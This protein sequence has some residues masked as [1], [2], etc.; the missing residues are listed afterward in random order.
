MSDILNE[1]YVKEGFPAAKKLYEIA[2]ERNLKVTMKQV[3]DFLANQET[4][5]L[6]RRKP[7]HI[8]RPI[9]TGAPQSEYQMD[10][11][12][13]SKFWHDN[14]GNRW[15][16]ICVDIFSRRASAQ[17][18]KDK[19]AETCL[20]ALKEVLKELGK[21]D[22]IVHDSGSEYKGAVAKYLKE[23]GI[24]Q[25]VTQPLDHHI[26]GIIDRF[27]Q[28]IKVIIYKYFTHNDTTKWIDEL[29]KIIKNYNMQVHSS[30]GGM[31]PND[32]NKYAS[33]VRKVQSERMEKREPVKK[34]NV[35]DTVKIKIHKGTFAKG[36]TINW[37]TDNYTIKETDGINYELSNGKS[38]RADSLFKVVPV[39]RTEPKKDVV[40]IAHKKHRTEQILKSD[41]IEEKNVQRTLRSR[42]PTDQLE[43]VRFGKI[44][45]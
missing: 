14:G 35:G 43:D 30:L 18:M 41:S 3:Q 23:E 19:K 25:R 12:D 29:P 5:Q 21:P 37:S 45:Y 40:K 7:K 17:A 16:L 10:L 15:I 39:R 31:N 22:I 42:K 28:T 2:K 36:Y 44:R 34:F 6:H 32:A 4:Y 24:L 27:S 33:D 20:K 38:Y 26:L 1:I 9:T 8:S 13:M 11:L